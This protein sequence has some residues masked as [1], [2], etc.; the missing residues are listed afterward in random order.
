MGRRLK[1]ISGLPAVITAIRERS[2]ENKTAFG[3]VLKVSHATISRYESGDVTPG[4]YPLLALFGL[5]KGHERRV[6]AEALRDVLGLRVVPTEEVIRDG[7][8]IAERGFSELVKIAA[9][10]PL[11][12]KAHRFVTEA[13][14]VSTIALTAPEEY[15]SE[16]VI[17]ILSLW[18]EYR[19]DPEIMRLFEHV[20]GYLSVSVAR[21]KGKPD[22]VV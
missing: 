7:L 18:R 11:S 15:P 17:E 12:T 6:I 13:L 1:K 16:V 3:R 4:H 22:V 2:G 14:Q 5:S 19:D 21:Q 20:L 10:T 8:A 9:K